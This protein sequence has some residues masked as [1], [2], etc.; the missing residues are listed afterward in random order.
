MLLP[1]TVSNPS[2]AAA[3]GNIKN[4]ANAA[5]TNNKLASLS[6]LMTQYNPAYAD[7][8]GW[9]DKS[10]TAL[11]TNQSFPMVDPTTQPATNIT[12]SFDY[13]VINISRPWFF[14]AYI[15]DTTWYV[16]GKQRGQLSANDPNS[17]T[18]NSVPVSVVAIKNLVIQGNWSA[19]DLALFKTQFGPFMVTSAGSTQLQCM[20]I[21]IVG[22]L[23]EKMPLLPPN[24]DPSLSNLL[25]VIDNTNTGQ[26]VSGFNSMPAITTAITFGTNQADPRIP[27]AG[28]FNGV[29]LEDG[30]SYDNTLVMVPPAVSPMGGM[31]MMGGFLQGILAAFTLSA[32][33]H[34]KAQAGFQPWGANGEPAPG[35]L[36]AIG[37]KQA[38]DPATQPALNIYNNQKYSTGNLIDID[39]DLSAYAGQQ[40]QLQININCGMIIGAAPLCFINPRVE[41]L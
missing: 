30:N 29:P 4:D 9:Y 41:Y 21:Q 3:F 10:Q 27:M 23:L 11:W 12:V 7:P 1:S 13:C 15:D 20:G 22:W 36:I 38:Q 24:A 39:I 26:W 2:N 14:D 19:A 6:G 18:L 28:L 5:W 35:V 32:P 40:I 31:N 34:F 16:Q 37:I 8:V 17:T 33:A 25:S